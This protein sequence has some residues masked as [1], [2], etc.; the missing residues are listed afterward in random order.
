M[1]LIKWLFLTFI[2]A[3]LFISI[4]VTWSLLNLPETESIKISRQPSIT[5]LDKEGRII[6]SYGDIY[7]QS[8]QFDDLPRNLINAVIVTEDKRFFFHPG[9]DLKGIIRAS[10]VNLKAGRIVQGGSTIT[11]QLAKNL[12]LTPERSFTRK[13][14]ELILS[15]WL[16]MRFSKEQLLSIYLNR[17]YLGSGTYGVQAASEKYFNKKVEELNLYEC[18]LIASLLKAPSKYNPIANEQL[19]RE[20]T[21]KVLENMH[22]SNLITAKNIAEAKNN[23]KKYNKFTSAPKST[24][25]FIDWLLPRVK[26]YLGEINEDLIVRTTL[27]VKLQELAEKSVN[28]ITSRFS[29]ADQSAL[30]ALDLDGGVKAMIGGRDYGDTQFNRVTQAQRQPG[31]AF[32]IFVYLAGL[33]EGYEPQDEIVD[34]AIDI[35]GWSPKN[36]K[37]EYLGEISLFEAFSKS[38]NTVAVKLSESIGRENVIKM[39]RSMGIT[40]PILNSPSLALGTSE[41]NLLELTAAYDVLANSGN[42]ILVHG[43]RSIENTSG[44]TL[45][46]RKGK[47]PG[48]V[49]DSELVNTMIKMMENTIETGTGKNARIN[50]PAAGKTGTSQSL[51]DAWFIGFSSELVVGV[52][53][54]NDDDSPM[55]NI[56]GGTAPAILWRDFMKKAHLGRAPQAL[57]SPITNIDKNKQNKNRIDRLIKKSKELEKKKNVFE[58][59][60]ENFF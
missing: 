18:A 10:Y 36:Y 37:K 17:V 33:K 35:N 29:S 27:D 19:S 51:R 7:G 15:F 11:Q 31:S 60:L 1:K 8:I 47:G 39:A 45:F 44:K 23:N 38:I 16:E 55:N 42:G 26:S 28:S 50:R 43:I 12:F 32:K 53:F 4:A 2:W 24:R 20:R 6:A 3:V 49:L 41:V 46:M 52:W 14:H 58:T 59:I 9:I 5:F 56:T 22:K 13:L 40:S 34:S 25:Y 21:S 57:T 48:K 54:G 30:V